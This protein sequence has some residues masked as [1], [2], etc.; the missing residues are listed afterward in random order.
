LSHVLI[1]TAVV[2]GGAFLLLWVVSLVVRDASIVDP[3]WGPSFAIVS[4]TAYAAAEDPGPRGLLVAILVTIWALRLGFHLAVRNLGK[5]EDFRY[6]DFRQRWGSKFWIVSLGTVFGVQATLMW[7]V[8][9]PVQVA[10]ID[11]GPPG[12][13][14]IAGVAVWSVGLFFEVVG[15]VQLARFKRDPANRGAVM[16]TGLWRFTRHPNYFGDF[17][18][19]WGHFLVSIARWGSLWTIVGPIVMSTLLL[20]VSGVTLLERSITARR[21]GYEDYVART[22]AFIPRRP[23]RQEPHPPSR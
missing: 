20:R 18:V 4:W 11:G 17:A 22:S 1:S 3:F 13:I 9:L 14:A 10:M 21:P 16:D 2:A 6:Q 15:D 8:S 5:G 23:R 12:F 7:I 19:W